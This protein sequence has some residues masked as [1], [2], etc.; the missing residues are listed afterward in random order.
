MVPPKQETQPYVTGPAI[1][2]GLGRCSRPLREGN[3]RVSREK[4]IKVVNFLLFSHELNPAYFFFSQLKK[5][6]EVTI[7]PEESR[8][9]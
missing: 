2:H 1:Q 7:T 8:R 5:E 9:E 3:L 6:A 4:S